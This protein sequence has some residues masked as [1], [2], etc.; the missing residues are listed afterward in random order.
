M[1]M[2]KIIAGIMAVC[3]MGTVMPSV[4]VITDNAVI[5]ANASGS[6]ESGNFRYDDDGTIVSLI[7]DTVSEITVPAVLDGTIITTIGP[8]VFANSLNLQKVV[9]SDG[10][11][12]I[13]DSAFQSCRLLEDVT[14][15]DSIKTIGNSAFSN[16]ISLK[17]IK[18]PEHVET[19]GY[20]A[21]S[22][23][24]A[25]ESL[26]FPSSVR[27]ISA[28]IAK[29]CTSLTQVTINNSQSIAD[30]AFSGCSNLEV[31]Y[32]PRNMAWISYS[33]TYSSST[34]YVNAFYNCS[35]LKDVYYAGSAEQWAKV[36]KYIWDNVSNESYTFASGVT[37]HFDKPKPSIMKYDVNRDGILDA[38]DASEVLRIYSILSTGGEL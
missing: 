22:E 38:T 12:T 32:I 29:D 10:I 35:K 3:V 2:K 37:M 9:I 34:Y 33:G 6:Y 24:A 15:P 11:K 28:S 36:K 8:S 21:F 20:S 1:N 30:E 5:T 25:L 13:G 16:C 14:L 27:E 31:V 7:D 19:I 26:N 18:I 17:E 4:N 23:C